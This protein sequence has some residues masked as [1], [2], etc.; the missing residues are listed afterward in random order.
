MIG[1]SALRERLNFF[2]ILY[3]IAAYSSQERHHVSSSKIVQLR[4]FRE[5][6]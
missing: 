6:N 5:K 2:S 1:S 4:L 3:K